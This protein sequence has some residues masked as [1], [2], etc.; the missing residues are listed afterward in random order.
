[1]L[2]AISMYCLPLIQHLP[3][4]MSIIHHSKKPCFN[5]AFSLSTCHVVDHCGFFFILLSK[6]SCVLA[7][8]GCEKDAEDLK[9]FVLYRRPRLVVLHMVS[10]YSLG[11]A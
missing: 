6:A 3:F 7:F 4:L 2:N 1:M 10:V 9:N 5:N 11:Q 8:C